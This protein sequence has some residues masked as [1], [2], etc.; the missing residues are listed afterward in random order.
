MGTGKC[1]H[2]CRLY[3]QGPGQGDIGRK[4]RQILLLLTQ[5]AETHFDT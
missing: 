4:E 2:N 3:N 5:R 1:S